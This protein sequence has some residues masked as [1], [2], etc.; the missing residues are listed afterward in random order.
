MKL[1]LFKTTL[2]TDD[3]ALGKRSKAAL[4]ACMM[5]PIDPSLYVGFSTSHMMEMGSGFQLAALKTIQIPSLLGHSCTAQFLAAYKKGVAA[6]EDAE[7]A[8]EH[9][10]TLMAGA[11]FNEQDFRVAAKI[12][13]DPMQPS[14]NESVI[15]VEKHLNSDLMLKGRLC[16]LREI[17][18][19]LR[20]RLNANVDVTFCAGMSLDEKTESGRERML[21]DFE[22]TNARLIELQKV[23]RGR[24][25]GKGGSEI[26]YPQLL[27]VK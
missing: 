8:V 19:A 1:R 22:E 5:Y 16:D 15:A 6:S 17:D 14:N 26:V 13:L 7:C 9:P 4:S 25:T 10:L 2:T 18:L 11:N 20:A 24:S 21:D 3:L 23:K 27:A 12:E